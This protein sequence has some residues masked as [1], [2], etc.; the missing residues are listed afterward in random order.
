MPVEYYLLAATGSVLAGI[1]NTLAG[2]GSAITMSI[3][4]YVVGMPAQQANATIR[5][6]ILGMTVGALPTYIR[7]GYVRQQR[8]ALLIYSL[9]AGAVLGIFT[10]VWIDASLFREIFKYLFIVML[11]LTLFNPKGWLRQTDEDNPLPAWVIVP[12]YLLLGFYGGF[13]QMGFGVFF[14]FV[15]VLAAKYNLIDA[16]G[17]KM[18]CVAI[19][20]PIAIAIFA[21]NGLIQWDFALAMMIGE[22]IGGRLGVHFATTQPKAAIW[23]HRLLIVVLVL[24]I[25]RAFWPD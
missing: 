10:A 20:T 1:V 11:L 18:F 19:Y 21:Y 15:T 12:L 13:I 7:K 16:G 14:L 17:L 22:M 8:D 4:M 2:N 5:L 6:G 25:I 9:S 23:A 3:L 24:S